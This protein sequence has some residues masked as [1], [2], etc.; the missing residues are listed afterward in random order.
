FHP[1]LERRQ[2]RERRIRIGL[3]IGR[4]RLG[5]LLE[6]LGTTVIAARTAGTSLTLEVGPRATSFRTALAAPTRRTIATRLTGRTRTLVAARAAIGTRR[7]ALPGS[8]DRLARLTLAAAIVR[9]A[10]IGAIA[11][12]ATGLALA[13]CALAATT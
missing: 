8:G 6:A 10:A 3:A 11:T 12:T 1:R 13:G 9:A 2:L 4:A 7:R 5:R